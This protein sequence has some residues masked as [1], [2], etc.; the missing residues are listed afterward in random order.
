[1]TTQS[2]EAEGGMAKFSISNID[3]EGGGIYRCSYKHP[4]R[5]FHFSGSS[6]PVE[7]LVLGEGTSFCI[8]QGIY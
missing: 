4:A 2:V 8:T 6:D 5:V 1:M 7:L 3:Q